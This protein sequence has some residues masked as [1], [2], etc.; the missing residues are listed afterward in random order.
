MDYLPYAAAV[1]AA[2]GA[3]VLWQQ[4]QQSVQELEYAPMVRKQAFDEPFADV[5]DDADVGEASTGIESAATDL[6]AVATTIGVGEGITAVAVKGA[7]KAGLKG[8]GGVVGVGLEVANQSDSKLLRDTAIKN[9]GHISPEAQAEL[10]AINN[11]YAE[12]NKKLDEAFKV[13]TGNKK[14]DVVVQAI[15]DGVRDTTVSPFVNGSRTLVNTTVGRAGRIAGAAKQEN[16][17][18]AARDT[19]A[20]ILDAPMGMARNVIVRGVGGNIVEAMVPEKDKQKAN[21]VLNAM[22][23]VSLVNAVK[24]VP[25]TKQ[26][27]DDLKAGRAPLFG[28]KPAPKPPALPPPPAPKKR[29]ETDIRKKLEEEL[30]NLKEKRAWADKKGKKTMKNR[31]DKQIEQKKQHLAKI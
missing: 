30:A 1:G 5:H 3:Y 15:A 23:E 9:A 13:D 18:K 29:T 20:E 24:T 19:T 17:A 8:A 7:T 27:A 31:L 22:A 25:V 26:E 28:V 10:E 2:V 6:V 14:A 12:T 11:D 16:K 4:S 21:E